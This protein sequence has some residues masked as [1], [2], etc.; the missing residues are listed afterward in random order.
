VRAALSPLYRVLE[1]A[2]LYAL[3]QRLGRPTTDRFRALIA[4]NLPLDTATSILDLGCGTGNYRGCFPGTYTGIDINAAYIEK[5]RA[6]LRGR[7]ETMDCT[8]LG[9]SDAGFDE[10]VTIA[11]T[12][13]L[14][15]AQL[16]R[17]VGEGL[18][19]CR[20]G[21]HLHIIDAILPVSPKFL[22]KRVWFRLDRGAFPRTV[23]DLVAGVE[24]AGRVIRRD[25]L[26]G[27]LHDTVYL[28]VAP[29]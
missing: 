22:F 29:I 13:H 28:R 23:E 2:G 19:V 9:F 17:M 8:A 24:R 26:T 6:T 10:V 3:N 20:P 5:A 25:M 15:D 16:A 7:F 1:L 18:R 21:G 11:T 27:P 14:D 12:H 4:G